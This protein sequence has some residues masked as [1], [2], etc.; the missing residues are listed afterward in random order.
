M[1]WLIVVLSICGYASL[2][3]AACRLYLVRMFAEY[4][5]LDSDDYAF[6]G[7]IGAFWPLSLIAFGIYLLGQY[8]LK[9]AVTPAAAKAQEKA[10]EAERERRNEL[11]RAGEL[12][13][14]YPISRYDYED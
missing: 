13:L 14:P 10:K 4:R 7:T 6:G 8:A 5:K 1:T 2:A 12:G 9:P 3:L 11:A